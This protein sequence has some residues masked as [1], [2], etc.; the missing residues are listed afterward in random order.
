MSPRLEV[1]TV[2]DK[3]LRGYYVVCH[4]SGSSL[5]R[6]TRYDG[7]MQKGKMSNKKKNSLDDVVRIKHL[8]YS[9]FGCA[10]P[11]SMSID[12]MLSATV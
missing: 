11:S 12:F 10:I 9:F 4:I 3:L 6:L 5:E 7:K 1:V 8:K 2:C